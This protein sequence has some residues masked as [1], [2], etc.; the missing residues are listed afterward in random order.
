MAA[1]KAL[2]NGYIDG[3][4]TAQWFASGAF[5]RIVPLYNAVHSDKKSLTAF[6][7]ISAI[8]LKY[9]QMVKIILQNQ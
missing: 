8:V 3:I 4:Y 7:L 1:V 6:S 2:E 5:Q 9:S